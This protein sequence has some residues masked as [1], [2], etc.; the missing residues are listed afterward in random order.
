V[1][2]KAGS[3]ILLMRQEASDLDRILGI[4]DIKDPEGIRPD[5]QIVPLNVHRHR[6]AIQAPGNIFQFLRDHGVSA[7]YREKPQKSQ[8]SEEDQQGQPLRVHDMLLHPR[9]FI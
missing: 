2:D 3:P 4:R 1:D 7:T 8:G 6:R 9:R 5:I